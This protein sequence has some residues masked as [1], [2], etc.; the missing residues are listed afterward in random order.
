MRK[1]ERDL[2]GVSEGGPGSARAFVGLGSNID[3]RRNVFRALEI[4]TEEPG[5]ELTGISTIYLTRAV[6]PPGPSGRA[7]QD[8]PDYLNCVLE[9]HT[10]LDPEPLYLRLLEVERLLG[11]VRSQDRYA[12]RT[13]DL[14]LLLYLPCDQGG[15][16][17][18]GL[19]G[20]AR[21][22]AVKSQ[23]SRGSVPGTMP[24]AVHQDVRTRP[25]VA[26]PLLELA[27]DLILPPDGVPLRTVAASLQ[28]PLGEAEAALTRRLRALFLKS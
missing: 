12:P 16:P 6:P 5:I 8:E 17:G 3:P 28:G 10:T 4:L 20:S 19:Q 21:D 25:F 11:R 22:P 18:H 23:S 13:M 1:G 15:G 7:P 26:V 2:A 9:L 27:P 24:P 14:D